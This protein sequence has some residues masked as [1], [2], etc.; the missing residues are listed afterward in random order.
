MEK[1]IN[2]Y[3]SDFSPLWGDAKGRGVTPN[4]NQSSS[5]W[6]PHKQGKKYLH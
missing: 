2:S 6:P 5:E 3:E 4:K 1:L